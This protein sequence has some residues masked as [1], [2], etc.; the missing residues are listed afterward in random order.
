MSATTT[1]GE[2]RFCFIAPMWNASAYVG[3][4]LASIVGQS[5]S[6]WK[7]ILI[8]DVSDKHEAMRQNEII[9]SWR[10]LIQPGWRGMNLTEPAKTKIEV[11]WNDEK[12]WEVAN[13]LRGISMCEDDDVICRI[14]ADDALCD[15][16]ALR[17]LNSTYN[18][19][20]CDVAW[21]MHRWGFSD[22]NISGPMPRDA[23]P[24][25]WPWCASHLKTFRKNLI[26]GIPYENFTN[27]NGDL[28]RRCGDQA[29]Y[30]PVLSRA[31]HRVFIP[32]A[33]YRYTINDV[34]ETYQTDDAKFQKTEAE[35]IRARGFVSQG[36]S[37][38]QHF[39]AC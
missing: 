4:M 2:N 30:L 13:V 8:D 21:S 3:Q 5:Y 15:L 16:D 38:E 29:I 27:M 26:N 32:R 22:K 18:M 7:V 24:Y 11:I 35:F 37:W 28:V 17:I 20:Q 25:T 36:N 9:N 1:S 12:K 10:D 19:Q 34:P 33:L 39:S 31:K 23:N 14:D 6:N